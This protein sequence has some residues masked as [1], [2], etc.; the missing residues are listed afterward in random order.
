MQKVC[1]HP[2]DRTYL[3]A[4]AIKHNPGRGVVN[5]RGER[6]MSVETHRVGGQYVD[7]LCVVD[8]E[9]RCLTPALVAGL[10]GGAG[11]GAQTGQS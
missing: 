2:Q 6:E 7:C 1:V 8:K 3:V 11:A 10:C 5:L 4:K 9:L